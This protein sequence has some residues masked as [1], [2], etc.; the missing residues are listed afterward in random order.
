MNNFNRRPGFFGG[1]S[2][3]PPIIKLL[4]VSNIAFYIIFN[5]L[6]SGYQIGSTSF[7]LIVTKY[8]ALNPLSP[9]LFRDE[10][11]IIQLGFY[12]WQL[13]TYM[14]LHGGFFHILLNMLALWMF[15]A[16][17][18]NIWGPK[19]FLTYYLIC[20]V[21]AGL[22]NILIAPLFGPVG[23][24]VGAS[25]AIYGI[26]V[27]F[28]YLFPDRNIYIY[29]LIPVKAKYLVIIYMLLALFSAGGGANDGVAHFAHLG[30]GVVGL[31]YLL[32]FYKGSA[33]KLFD[34]K[35]LKEKFTSYTS[36]GRKTYSPPVFSNG[37]NPRK[38]DIND[39]KYQDL[40]ITDYKKDIETQER[41]AQERID[42]ILDKLSE[43]GYQSLTE[44]EKRV[45]FQESKKL[46]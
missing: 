9:V 32:I 7:D 27:A 13:I 23:P 21:G 20:G 43:G 39:A 28:G 44:E 4:L 10:G 41:L 1:F 37:S 25:G 40:E 11:Q 42:A 6:L 36:S 34:N 46:R 30:G 45:L 5:I 26:L 12:P 29:G 19:R 8:F 14:F 17:L 31:I 33:S 2:L 3:F 24:T 38:E 15:G 22:C 18:E 35:G 16:E